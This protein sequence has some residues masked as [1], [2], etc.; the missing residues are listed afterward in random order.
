VKVAEGALLPTVSVNAK[1]LQQYGSFLGYPGSRQFSA[2]ALGAIDV[3]LYQGGAEYA[4]VRRAKEVVGKA[5]LAVDSQRLTAR[6]G[7]VA[8]FGQLRA[9]KA[10][11]VADQ[12]AVAAAET[13]LKGVRDEAQFGQR[14]TLDLLDAQQALLD[15][16]VRLGAS[17]RDRVVSSYAASS[18]MG[19]L[20]AA[21][22]GLDAPIYDPRA[23]FDAV[24]D[25][26]LGLEPAG[27]MTV[28]EP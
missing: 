5:R 24:R 19:R 3:P 17:R 11:I 15:A 1:V 2:Q 4:S 28:G 23:H 27:Q 25:K 22:L 7:V 26:K 14:T 9:A 10:R 12:A 6:A 16:R 8:S 20:S 18:A 21:T 13:A